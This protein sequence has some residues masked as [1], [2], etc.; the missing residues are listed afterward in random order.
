MELNTEQKREVRDYVS[1]KTCYRETYN[2]VYDHVLNSLKDN[3]TSCDNDTLEQILNDDFGGVKGIALQEKNH[4][5]ALG[6]KY[7]KHFRERFFETAKWE[8]IPILLFSLMYYF[9]A[10]SSSFNFEPTFK[11][12][13]SLSI[14]IV[15]VGF[16][17]ILCNRIRHS[18][19]SIFDY[20]LALVSVFSIVIINAFIKLLMSEDFVGLDPS[21]IHKATLFLMVIVILHFRTF[22]KIFKE[23]TPVLTT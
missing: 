20:Y 3:H 6:K 22:V 9:G 14:G 21:Q 23:R 19:F 13:T 5:K 8:G 10:E 4:Q 7:M 18:K 16:A 2:E 11:V 17:K 1:S 15:L 12:T